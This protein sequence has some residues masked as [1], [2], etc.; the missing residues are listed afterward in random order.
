MVPD[1]PLISV[2]VPS[3]E[4]PLRLRWLLNAL[5]EQTLERADFEV[6]VAHDSGPETEALLREHPLAVR[7]IALEPCGPA[8]KRNAAWRAARAPLVAFTDDDCRP[9]PEWLAGLMA[10]ARE[11]PGGVVQGRVAID[12][13]ELALLHH[14]PWSRSQEVDPPSPYGQT[15]NIVYPRDLLERAGG[16]DE[17]LPVAAGEDTDLLMRARALGA[18]YT[19]APA[20]VIYHAV[21][22]GTLAARMRDAWRWQ[23]LALIVRRYPE[24]RRHLVLRT[25]WKVEHP[26]LLLALAGA[27]TRRPL[28]ALPW[29]LRRLGGYG[30]GPRARIRAATELPGR[31]ILDT[32]EVA[33]AVRGSVRYRTIYL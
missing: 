15:A 12:P 10:A 8:A 28:L 1:A 33:S 21:F 24:L 26:L 16:F 7:A 32:T 20:V 18:A 14:A 5:E 3:H 27:A 4:R 29:V 31:A 25:F 2:V 22:P 9:P 17:S 6:I 11:N 19:G 30:R 23:H 13:D